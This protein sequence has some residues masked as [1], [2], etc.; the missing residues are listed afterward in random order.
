M[1]QL[2]KFLDNQVATVAAAKDKNAAT[3]AALEKIRAANKLDL[4]ETVEIN[5]TIEFIYKIENVNAS[6]FITA[7]ANKNPRTWKKL[8]YILL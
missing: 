3:T 7:T 6:V 8:S 4:R 1:K 2:V 5:G